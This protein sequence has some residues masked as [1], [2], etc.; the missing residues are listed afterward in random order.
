M[1]CC[2]LLR[3]Y[4]C[5]KILHS[6]FAVAGDHVSQDP[7]WNYYV[8]RLNKLRWL[9]CTYRTRQEGRTCGF[10]ILNSSSPFRSLALYLCEFV[11][12]VIIVLTIYTVT[13]IGDACNVVSR[14]DTLHDSADLE[15]PQMTYTIPVT[16][17][18]GHCEKYGKIWRGQFALVY[19]TPISTIVYSYTG[20][21][22]NMVLSMNGH[23]TLMYCVLLSCSTKRYK[24]KWTNGYVKVLDAHQYFRYLI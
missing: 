4:Y 7:Y 18:F 3:L 19:P 12:V 9:G 22:P 10:L 24:Y 1:V 8:I 17:N 11:I 13:A 2:W 20:T 23:R 15:S 5:M 6:F 14:H 16:A 21:K